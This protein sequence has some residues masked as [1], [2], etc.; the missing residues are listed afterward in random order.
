MEMNNK[1][2]QCQHSDFTNSDPPGRSP[3][4]PTADQVMSEGRGG[5][6]EGVTLAGAVP[7][8]WAIVLW[9]SDWSMIHSELADLVPL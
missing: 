9:Y 1:N 7:Q 2:N 8:D 4:F 6:R 3:W 5:C